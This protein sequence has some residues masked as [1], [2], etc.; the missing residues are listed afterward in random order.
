M[1]GMIGRNRKG[2]KRKSGRRTSCGDLA[3]EKPFDI[4]ALAAANPDRRDLPEKLR[5]SEKASSQIG[6]LNLLN[7]LTDQQYEA[8]RRF[9]V[10]VG[11]FRAVIGTPR[12]TSGGGKGYLCQ[13]ESCLMDSTNCLCELRTANFREC[14]S[15]LIGVGQRVYNCTYRTAISDEP[16]NGDELACV[17]LGLNA[18][19]RLFGIDKR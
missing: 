17:K 6:K 18:L 1:H 3:R 16:A 11:A 7:Q 13:P 5:L 2:R 8:G 4:R 19:V 12:G 15:V 9:Q 10:I 14:C